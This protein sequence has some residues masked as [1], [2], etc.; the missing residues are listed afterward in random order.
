MK[1]FLKILLI[2]LWAG[3]A[4]GAIILMSFANQN[5]ESKSCTG[6]DVKMDYAGNEPMFTVGDIKKQ[7]K[8]TFGEF[9]KK[10]L[11]ELDLEGIQAFLQKNPYVDYADVHTTIEGRLVIEVTQCK[12]VVRLITLS[13]MNYYLDDK[14][15][16]IPVNPDYPVRVI[17]ASGNISTPL[18]P[19][20][21]I[22]E[23]HKRK[24]DSE[25]AMKILHNIHSLAKQ[26]KNDSVMNA[27]VEQI[28]IKPNGNIQLATKAGSHVIEFGDT[29]S[30]TEKI[31][32][33]KAFYKYGLT[34]TGWKKYRIINLTY[35]NQ[36]VCT[37]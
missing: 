18:S 12:P 25:P 6:V 23:K 33:L 7:L 10:R 4:A 22:F 21:S 15:K 3:L 27:L 19:G 5:H 35:K 31:E 34:K 37:K 36:V 24:P 1:L 11:I 13:G 20:K 14:G 8:G 28:Y 32:N 9:E 17:V 2:A 16:L 29:A 26:L 30:A